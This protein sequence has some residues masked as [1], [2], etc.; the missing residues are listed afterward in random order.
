MAGTLNVGATKIFIFEQSTHET[1]TYTIDSASIFP[2]GFELL[3]ISVQTL[4]AG[5]PAG[6]MTIY[7]DAI[8]VLQEANTVTTALGVLTP[9]LSRTSSALNFTG[10][11]NLIIVTAGDTSQNRVV[12]E[13][14]EYAPRSVTVS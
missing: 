13:V 10:A 4:V 14:C 8:N 11:E 1:A 5:A 9:E 2:T 12:I 7:K 3:S 6:T